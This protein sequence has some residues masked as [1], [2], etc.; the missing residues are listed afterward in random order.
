MSEQ[1]IEQENEQSMT[2]EES[3]AQVEQII[4]QMEQKDI[5]LDASF[6]LYQEGIKQLQNCNSL[7]DQ[8]EKSLQIINGEG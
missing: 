4:A 2:I 5:S 8:V 1:I 7:L 6:S 3:F